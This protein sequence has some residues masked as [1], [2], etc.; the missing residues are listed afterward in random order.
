MADTTLPARLLH[1]SASPAEEELP[2]RSD[3]DNGTPRHSTNETSAKGILHRI[4]ST[5][6]P[7]IATTQTRQQETL[8]RFL[9]TAENLGDFALCLLD[10]QDIDA[11]ASHL[12]DE[13]RRVAPTG[14]TLEVETFIERIK[15]GIQPLEDAYWTLT[16]GTSAALTHLLSD[17]L[18]TLELSD[19]VTFEYVPY[20]IVAYLTRADFSKYDRSLTPQ[21]VRDDS[22][23]AIKG[24]LIIIPMEDAWGRRVQPKT[25]RLIRDRLLLSMFAELYRPE[26]LVLKVEDVLLQ[27][28]G[29]LRAS[30]ATRCARDS[31]SLLDHTLWREEIGAFLT[32]NLEEDLVEE[33]YLKAMCTQLLSFHSSLSFYL[34]RLE[35]ASTGAYRAASYQFTDALLAHLTSA[36]ERHSLAKRI[37]YALEDTTLSFATA[38]GILLLS[39]PGG[40][41]DLLRVL[42]VERKDHLREL[43]GKGVD[44]QLDPEGGLLP[45]REWFLNRALPISPLLKTLKEARGKGEA[46]YYLCLLKLLLPLASRRQRSK[47]VDEIEVWHAAHAE[48][49][50]GEMSKLVEQTLRAARIDYPHELFIK[51]L[52]ASSLSDNEARKS[53][54]KGL[55]SQ[56]PPD[57]ESWGA[58]LIPITLLECSSKSDLEIL[59]VVLRSS[60]H[61]EQVRE[62]TTQLLKLF[63][64]YSYPPRRLLEVVPAC[65]EAA[66][67]V[68]GSYGSEGAVG[69]M[70]LLI[71]LYQYLW[72]KVGDPLVQDAFD[73]SE[74][75][76]TLPLRK[77]AEYLPPHEPFFWQPEII[78]ASWAYDVGGHD[79]DVLSTLVSKSASVVVLKHC[80]ER[81]ARHLEK[82]R[83][84]PALFPKIRDDLEV[85][86]H[87]LS[88]GRE[89]IGEENLSE[90]LSILLKLYREL[91]TRLERQ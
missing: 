81:L 74:E 35:R 23:E 47:A 72:K 39:G 26:P 43:H 46:R 49:P 59:V 27:T 34:P 82:G 90:C 50:D 38:L 65:I 53:A 60:M 36:I 70:E 14:V 58:G 48:W 10:N 79:A 69:C 33:V 41:E 78:S 55:L 88:S 64:E 66:K 63:A 67:F 1:S 56:V 24:R 25:L 62:A 52:Y 16:R 86:L 28:S 85:S 12:L 83:V 15:L 87:F 91:S 57:K 31:C 51:G 84:P 17:T 22:A 45:A 8:S 21:V 40:T 6:A 89:V 30:T 73:A 5:A 77:L 20:A 18:K 32:L 76:R 68:A 2:F 13:V 11:A 61:L 29:K 71:D 3:P 37:G 7:L 42:G 75:T 9:S 4:L 19:Q 54:L 44:Y 80:G